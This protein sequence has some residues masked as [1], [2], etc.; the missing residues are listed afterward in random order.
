MLQTAAGYAV[1]SWVL[2]QVAEVLQD[3]LPAGT[4]RALLIGLTAI[5]LINVFFHAPL[6]GRG[7]GVSLLI[8]LLAV[9]ALANIPFPDLCTLD[10]AAGSDGA[11]VFT[12]PDAVRQ[13][14]RLFA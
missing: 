6:D 2:L 4:L 7:G 14:R 12:L 8:A 9:P 5:G 1:V 11:V 10:N 13:V 3:M